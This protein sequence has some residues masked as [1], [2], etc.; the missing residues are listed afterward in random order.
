MAIKRAKAMGLAN[1]S[2]YAAHKNM[3][4]ALDVLMGDPELKVNA[5]ILPGHV[6]TIIGMKPYQFWP[7]NTTSLA[8]SPGSSRLT[9][10]RASP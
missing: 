6:S 10:S 1:F 9:Y 7:R 2:V 4:G 8:L 3:P 5:L